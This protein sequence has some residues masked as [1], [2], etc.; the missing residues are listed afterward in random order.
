MKL[1]CNFFFNTV[2]IKI[3][4]PKWNPRC[5]PEVFM[6]NIFFC[7]IICILDFWSFFLFIFLH[8][9][10]YWISVL[11]VID[12]TYRWNVCWYFHILY[13]WSKVLKPPCCLLSPELYFSFCFEFFESI[14]LHKSKLV[15]QKV[16]KFIRIF[17]SECYL[18]KFVEYF[19]SEGY[20]RGRGMLWFV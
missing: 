20:C 12:N 2:N 3:S 18:I 6:I 10:H 17:F 8:N 14:S 4:N 19:N 5:Y 7:F 13:F 11:N 15:H 1:L 9:F 16:I